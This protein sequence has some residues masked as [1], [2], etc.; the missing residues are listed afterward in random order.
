MVFNCLTSR[1]RHAFMSLP[2]HYTYVADAMAKLCEC[3]QRPTHR[4]VNSHWKREKNKMFPSILCAFALITHYVCC[5]K[6][7]KTIMGTGSGQVALAKTSTWHKRNKRNRH[8]SSF[9]CCCCLANALVRLEYDGKTLDAWF[10]RGF[11]CFRRFFSCKCN[12]G[13]VIARK[14]GRWLAFIIQIEQTIEPNAVASNVSTLI[15]IL[16]AV[17]RRQF[18]ILFEFECCFFHV[19]LLSLIFFL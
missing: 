6:G 3:V 12:D 15:I 16:I 1:M 8:N 9:C 14:S 11:F 17:G 10:N 19:D 2:L 18:P 5:E 7:E 4:P 13:H